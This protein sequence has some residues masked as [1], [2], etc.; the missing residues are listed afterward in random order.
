MASIQ[1]EGEVTRTLEN[2]VAS[3]SFSFAMLQGN[4]SGS[5]SRSCSD[6]SYLHAHLTFSYPCEQFKVTASHIFSNPILT[7]WI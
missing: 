4:C 5:S 2:H 7:E 1:M 6:V 3:E